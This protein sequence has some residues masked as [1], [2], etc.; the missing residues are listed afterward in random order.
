MPISMSKRKITNGNSEPARLGRNRK[1]R[2]WLSGNLLP[3]SANANP[4][5]KLNSFPKP[6]IINFPSGG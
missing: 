3:I 4:G 6:A 5:S 1:I 2:Y